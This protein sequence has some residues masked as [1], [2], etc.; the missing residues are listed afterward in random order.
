M[1]H[2]TAQCSSLAY[3]AKTEPQLAYT[4]YV[5][6][7]SKRCSFNSSTTPNIG[8]H[9]KKLEHEIKETLIP[10]IASK[11]YISRSLTIPEGYSACQHDYNPVPWP[12][13]FWVRGRVHSSTVTV[14]AKILP[15]E[16]FQTRKDICGEK[17]EEIARMFNSCGAK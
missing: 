2:H 6:S 11:N 16:R 14:P 12:S 15:C 7:T 17:C 9:L 3:A 4:G 8:K 13:I 10:A 1:G 5:Y